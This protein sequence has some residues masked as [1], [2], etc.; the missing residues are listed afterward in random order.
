M[1]GR[2]TWTQRVILPETRW[3]A[4]RMRL[5]SDTHY[6][7]SPINFFIFV[8]FLKI[9]YQARFCFQISHPAISFTMLKWLLNCGSFLVYVL[10]LE[11]SEAFTLS[12]FLPGKRVHSVLPGTCDMHCSLKRNTLHSCLYKVYMDMSNEID[13]FIVSKCNAVVAYSKIT[14]NIDSKL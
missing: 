10:L 9:L 8:F 4:R 5:S 3:P 12:G 2:T 11:T 1:P 7:P 13:F 14:F 6:N